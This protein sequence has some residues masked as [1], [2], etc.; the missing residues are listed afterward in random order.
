[1]Q[2]DEGNK[3]EY[4]NCPINWISRGIWEFARKYNRITEG[5][6]A[7]R[8]YEDESAWFNFAVSYYQNWHTYFLK[9]KNPDG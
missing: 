1:M 7:P 8:Y 6:A 2:D 4:Y 5:L 9:R 3:I